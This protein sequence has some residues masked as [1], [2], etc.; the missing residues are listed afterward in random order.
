MLLEGVVGADLPSTL[1]AAAKSS[2]NPDEHLLCIRNK[3]N[4]KLILKRDNFIIHENMTY[5]PKSGLPHPHMTDP[6]H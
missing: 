6:D 2:A 5:S 3:K 4:S 1:S